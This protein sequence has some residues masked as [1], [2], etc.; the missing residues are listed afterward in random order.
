[1]NFLLGVDHAGP[2]DLTHCGR[3]NLTALRKSNQIQVQR[4][5]IVEIS[6]TWVLGFYHEEHEENVGEEY[7][8][9]KSDDVEM[10]FLDDSILESE[11]LQ[12]DLLLLK[13]SD[14]PGASLNGKR[15]TELNVVQ[16]KRWLVCHGAPSTGRKP[17]L[18]KR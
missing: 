3:F 4:P 15:P 17:E 18:I 11:F 13:E 8:C 1:M 7:E 10:A 2:E 12:D 16:L 5:L 6:F 14:I 9:H